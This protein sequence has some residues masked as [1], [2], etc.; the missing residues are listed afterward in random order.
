MRPSFLLL[1]VLISLPTIASAQSFFGPI[2]PQCG[3]CGCGILE[4]VQLINNLLRFA[5]SLGVVVATLIFAY[6]GFLLVTSPTNPGNIARAKSMFLNTLIGFLFVLGAY[7][8]VDT[9]MKTFST[10]PGWESVIPSGTSRCTEPSVPSGN[11]GGVQ[12]G[13]GTAG[14]PTCTSLTSAGLTCK[15]ASSCTVTPEAASKLA[16]LNSNFNGEW[17]I[18]EAYPPTVN[19]ANAC[20][21][22]GTCV[23]VGFRGGTTYTA[24]NIKEFVSAS[25]A[26]GLRAVYETK[27]SS[28]RDTLVA[29]G[30]PA[31]NIQVISWITAPHFSVYSN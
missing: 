4:F 28:E 12:T 13:G 1:A 26:A 8:I 10:F 18:T 9:I 6:A 24:D 29:A 14:C 31:G 27:S 2:V 25:S 23:D 16:V 17:T 30:V 19:H 11:T 7:L 21:K 5:V 15:I 3:D 20:H 22:N